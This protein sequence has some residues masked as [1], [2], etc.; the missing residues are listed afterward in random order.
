MAELLTVDPVTIPEEIDGRGLLREGFDK[1]LSRP[2]GGGMLG[3]VEVDDAPAVVSEHDED[4]EGPEASGGYGEKVDR[5]QVADVVGE[6]CPP[7][8]RG[9]G[10]A[11]PHEPGDGALG[12]RDAK[13]QELSVDAR[14]APERIC[15]GH[16]ADQSGDLGVEG[17]APSGLTARE[18]GPIL[19][20]A[21]APPAEDGV[22][23]DDDQRLSPA[24]PDSGQPG[25]EKAIGRAEL[26]PRGRS[27][28]DGE[29]LAHGQVREG[30][31][32][33]PPTMKRRNRSWE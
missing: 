15:G 30:E 6:K 5:N 4:E 27:L 2:G 33:M 18:P 23:R 21:A 14:G 17:R 32:A 31:L 22:G 13:L 7:G 16:P 29:L 9:A 10:A 11:L 24:G 1:L 3:D 28:V 8:L 25:P 12:N 19:A 26:W 20:E